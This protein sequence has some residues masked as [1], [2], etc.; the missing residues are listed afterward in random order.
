MKKIAFIILLF[1]L[2][3]FPVFS[4][5]SVITEPNGYVKINYQ[6]YGGYKWAYQEE[7]DKGIPITIEFSHEL[8]ETYFSK[9]DFCNGDPNWKLYY[10]YNISCDNDYN[11]N[12]QGNS[13]PIFDLILHKKGVNCNIFANISIIYKKQNDDGSCSDTTIHEFKYFN[14]SLLSDLAVLNKTPASDWDFQGEWQ[15]CQR[16]N[17]N[18]YSCQISVGLNREQGDILFKTDPSNSPQFK[19]ECNLA[20][21]GDG[22][23]FDSNN[24]QLLFGDQVIE[25][26][27]VN[28]LNCQ[29]TDEYGSMKLCPYTIEHQAGGIYSIVLGPCQPEWYRTIASDDDYF[30]IQCSGNVSVIAHAHEGDITQTYPLELPKARYNVTGILDAKPLAQLI[31]ESIQN[32]TASLQ[33]ASMLYASIHAYQET[34]AMLLIA[35]G[36]LASTHIDC[37]PLDLEKNMEGKTDWGNAL[38][39]VLFMSKIM[40]CQTANLAYNTIKTYMLFTILKKLDDSSVKVKVNDQIVEYNRLSSWLKSNIQKI[41]T[42]ITMQASLCTLGAFKLL[43]NKENLEV[44]DKD[45]LYLQVFKFV[46]NDYYNVVKDY[47]KYKRDCENGKVE[48]IWSKQCK[49]KLKNWENDKNIEKFFQDVCEDST[50]LPFCQ[51]ICKGVF[52]Q[53]QRGNKTSNNQQQN[54]MKKLVDKICNPTTITSETTTLQKC[55]DYVLNA[56][57]LNEIPNPQFKQCLA[58]NNY[59]PDAIIPCAIVSFLELKNKFIDSIQ[60]KIQVP[61]KLTCFYSNNI[62]ECKCDNVKPILV[63]RNSLI[64]MPNQITVGF[65]PFNVEIDASSIAENKK[66]LLKL[67]PQMLCELISGKSIEIGGILIVNLFGRQVDIDC[68]PQR[69]NVLIRFYDH[70]TGKCALL[71]VESES[72][73]NIE[74]VESDSITLKVSNVEDCS[75][76]ITKPVE[77]GSKQLT[78]TIVSNGK[79]TSS[80]FSCSTK[81]NKLKCKSTNSNEEIQLTCDNLDYDSKKELIQ[82]S[83][84]NVVAY[85]NPYELIDKNE[86]P[87]I[88]SV[89]LKDGK[90]NIECYNDITT[91]LRNTKD[92]TIPVSE[93]KFKGLVLQ[94]FEE[95]DRKIEISCSN[96]LPQDI[97]EKLTKLVVDAIFNSGI[98]FGLIGEG[99]IEKTVYQPKVLYKLSTCEGNNCNDCKSCCSENDKFNPPSSVTFTSEINKEEIIVELNGVKGTLS[100]IDC[101]LLNT[102]KDAI[103]SIQSQKT[104][105]ERE[106]NVL[107]GYNDE[108]KAELCSVANNKLESITYILSTIWTIAMDDLGKRISLLGYATKAMT[109]CY[110]GD[111][112]F[113]MFFFWVGPDLA[114]EFN[115]YCGFSSIKSVKVAVKVNKDSSLVERF[116][117][118]IAG[119]IG[120]MCA[121]MNINSYCTSQTYD[122]LAVSNWNNI[123][124]SSF[125]F[126]PFVGKTLDDILGTE[127]PSTPKLTAIIA[128]KPERPVYEAKADWSDSGEIFGLPYHASIQ[129]SGM[130]G[131]LTNFIAQSFETVMVPCALAIS[132]RLNDLVQMVQKNQQCLVAYIAPN[133]FEGLKTQTT[134]Q[135]LQDELE[136]L[137][138]ALDSLNNEEIDNSI[139]QLNQVLDNISQL[140]HQLALEDIGIYTVPP[141]QDTQ[142]MDELQKFWT[143]YDLWYKM[144]EFKKKLENL[145]TDIETRPN[146]DPTL[147]AK[148]LDKINEAINLVDQ[149]INAIPKPLRDYFEEREVQLM[150]PFNQI[151]LIANIINNPDK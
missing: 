26:A 19:V 85:L 144:N 54:I 11:N 71:T 140:A 67:S 80:T 114:K 149:I 109:E 118:L 7:L 130:L 43:S 116:L 143:Y 77:I 100:K 18:F 35:F 24:C 44:N 105:F 142:N 39:K 110:A 150:Q 15:N 42:T 76:P 88:K 10:N 113:S 112:W 8:T 22:F 86:C 60:S 70:E 47:L 145:K 123:F 36:R 6:I 9:D 139:E 127:V 74:K 41:M 148:M 69:D 133:Y 90:I 91:H 25:E 95:S 65:N 126:I 2:A 83:C 122:V 21:E 66:E 51:D 79:E 27:K 98:L 97:K 46:C 146:I 82:M 134:I 16:I 1:F 136:R 34:A 72:L 55:V 37:P 131:S 13:D 61:T 14:M 12:Y 94:S 62:I 138:P 49:A 3:F 87:S 56:K 84:N 141:I 106:V 119:P 117:P 40:W 59:N 75:K 104:S 52:S 29:L 103:S 135:Q 78:L 23:N 107:A 73:N 132:R 151:D 115:A 101:S 137:K 17:D 28:S 50:N 121:W 31:A 45:N 32:L 53:S 89:Y 81:N 108:K 120:A 68:I 64:A 33:Q 96:N 147:K 102:L 5:N 125:S 57:A 92:I 124:P 20:Y 48:K 129:G 93:S 4:D 30:D 38:E 63:D 128:L 58:N 99:T 111:Y